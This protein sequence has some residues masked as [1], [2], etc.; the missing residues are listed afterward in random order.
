VQLDGGSLIDPVNA[1][2][3]KFFVLEQG[4]TSIL[5]VSDPEAQI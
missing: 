5:N 4:V 3:R 1:L 2:A